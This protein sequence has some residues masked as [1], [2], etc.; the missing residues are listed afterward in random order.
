[1]D[2]SLKLNRHTLHHPILRS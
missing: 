1:M 2:R